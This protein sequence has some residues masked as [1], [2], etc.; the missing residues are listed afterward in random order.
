MSPAFIGILQT[1]FANFD[2]FKGA[3]FSD[4]KIFSSLIRFAS[5]AILCI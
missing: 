4:I 5:G 1:P 3:Q 2:F